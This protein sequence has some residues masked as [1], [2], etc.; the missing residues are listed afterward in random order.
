MNTPRTRPTRLSIPLSP[1]LQVAYQGLAEV[2][3]RSTGSV[4]AEWLKDTLPAAVSMTEQIRRMKSTP[5]VT[6]ARMD[7]MLD[8][9][10]EMTLQVMQKAQRG[11]EPGAGGASVRG[12]PATGSTPLTPPS[13]N[14]GGKVGKSSKSPRA[15]K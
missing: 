6:I 15:S 2:L 9:S 5:A 4:I 13:S 12:T 3:G 8:V 1:E 11:V 14:T 10:E 7:A